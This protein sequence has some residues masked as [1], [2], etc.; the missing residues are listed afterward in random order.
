M[1]RIPKLQLEIN[2]LVSRN[3]LLTKYKIALSSVCLHVYG[4]EHILCLIIL[5][6]HG[7]EHYQ[8]LLLLNFHLHI[9]YFSKVYAYVCEI[10]FLLINICHF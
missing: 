5:M 6:M 4:I 8:F 10:I 9:F 3:V 2:I 1:A 7:H